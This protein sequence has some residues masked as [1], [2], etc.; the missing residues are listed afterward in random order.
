MKNTHYEQNSKEFNK[1][2]VD[3]TMVPEETPAAPSDET[4][5]NIATNDT[6]APISSSVPG[7][8]ENEEK[9]SSADNS[10]NPSD[11]IPESSDNRCVAGVVGKCTRLNVRSEPSL[12]AMVL[13]VIDRS[14]EVAVDTDFSNSEWYKVQTANGTNGFCMKKF[15]KVQ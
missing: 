2:P 11:P 14:D 6:A 13:A 7:E 4:A 8:F 10:D 3:G 9:L 15:I 1:V 5:V 12:T